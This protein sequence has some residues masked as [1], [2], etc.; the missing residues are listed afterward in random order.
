MASNQKVVYI[1]SLAFPE[2]IYRIKLSVQELQYSSQ[3]TADEISPVLVVR[4]SAQTIYEGDPYNLTCEIIA[5]PQAQAGD[6]TWRRNT[7]PLW[8][9]D[10]GS[11][12]VAASPTYD[13]EDRLYLL[14]TNSHYDTL[15]FT[16]LKSADRAVYV[17]SVRTTVGNNSNGIFVRV[18]I[19][20]KT[21]PIK[22]ILTAAE[23]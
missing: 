11:G 15:S 3:N 17:C 12:R 8:V 19:P 10:P 20:H 2:I 9:E 13:P 18:K 22:E 23:V 5:Y 4:P 1:N 7:Q 6:I 21:L 16:S 14:S